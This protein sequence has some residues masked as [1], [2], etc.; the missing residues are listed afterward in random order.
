MTPAKAARVRAAFVEGK[1]DLAKVRRAKAK[2]AQEA[3]ANRPTITRLWETY[4]AARPNLK[5]IVTDENRY[6]LH[7]APTF[8]DKTP[9]E[10]DPLSIDRFR[11]RLGKTLTPK[12]TANVLEL[13]RRIINFGRNRGLCDSRLRIQLPKVDNLRTEDLSAEQL[14]RLME[15][16][17]RTENQS[18]ARI[19]RMALFTGMRKGEILKLKWGD[20]DF[21]RGFITIRDPKGGQSVKVP[22]S[23]QA[24]DLLTSL[25]RE[26]EY[27][28]PGRG[29]EQRVEVR[30]AARKICDAAGL[31]QNFRPMH[32]LRHAYASML[33]S[34][35]KVD[36][37][38]LQRLLTH[39]SAAMTQRYAHLHDEALQ[40]AAAVAGGLI[41][42]AV[43][44]GE[45]GKVIPIT[46]GNR[47]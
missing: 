6:Q 2:A 31:P 40:R 38:T 28:F 3:E 47:G 9:A 29:G 23:P 11:V 1:R 14:S 20:L 43:K 24:R 30:R 39:K 13:L 10:I 35:G 44:A 5:G 4:K 19:M 34:S 12:T 32:G 42:D 37:Y 45:P 25:P 16:L 27:V 46:S 15:A 17:N 18:V 8:A 41:D 26:S 33:A 36:L 21:D 7:I 22:M